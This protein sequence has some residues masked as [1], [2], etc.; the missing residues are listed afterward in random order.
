MTAPD[1]PP[2][3]ADATGRRTGSAG[4]AQP[5]DT[6]DGLTVAALELAEAGW[7]IFRL[8]GK[9][10]MVGRHPECK[11]S[12]CHGGCG[13]EGHGVFDAT[14][15][16]VV[17]ARWW[18][19]TPHANIAARVPAG[20]FVL[21]VDPRHDGDAAM[22]ELVEQHG[23]LP[24][25]LSSASGRGDGG[26]HYYFR[27]PGGRLIAP[28]PGLDIK[29]SAGYVV[30]PPSIHPDTGRPYRWVTPGPIGDPPWWLIGM[31]R[32]APRSRPHPKRSI[33][34]PTRHGESPADWYTRT[35]TWGDVLGPHGWTLVSGD[36]D[37][38]GSAWRHPA[39]TSL[40]SATIRFGL[41]FVYST[42]TPF[43][44]TTS[45]D[46]HGNTK[47]RA[48]AQLDHAGDLSAAARAVRRQMKAVAS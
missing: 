44:A 34:T 17:V 33:W 15:D 3:A 22:A 43:E 28:G 26:R 4:G 32:P 41:L 1:A 24:P 13:R 45:S 48:F 37:S 9:V 12:E 27:H 2:P 23:E 20:L 31:M 39:A 29:T 40:L 7:E 21:D 16:P 5:Q 8:R 25:T 47:F 30:L 11:A 46:P 35:H 36:G 42:S 19:E 6:P 14:S 18:H 38:D 10:P